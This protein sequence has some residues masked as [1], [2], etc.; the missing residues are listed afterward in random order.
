MLYPL[1]G[2]TTELALGVW[3]SSAKYFWAGDYVQNG[4]GSPYARDVV[5][6]VRGLGLKPDKIGAQ[7]IK[8]ADWRELEARFPPG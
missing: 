7:H 6:T 1:R 8:L 3:V 2:A 4:P 5:R